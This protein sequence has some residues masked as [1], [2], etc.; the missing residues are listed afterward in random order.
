MKEQSTTKGFAILS[1]A[2]M[3]VKVLSILYIPFLLRI[4]GNEGYG[5]YMAAYQVYVFIYV[6][7]NS[8]IPVAISKMVSELIAVNNYRDAVKGFK[9]ARF[10]LL[11]LG[12]VLTV[13]MMIL[14]HPLAKFVHYEKASLAI[15]ALAPA[16]FFTSVAST[17]RG[18]FQGRGNMTPTAVSQVLEQITNTI[19]T[20]VFAG[21]LI[22]NG[23]AA[24]C[25]GGTIGT[26]LGA[27]V[28]AGY[29]IV[30]YEKNRR[31]K[32]PKGYKEMEV[33]RLTN[34]QILMR[35]IYYSLPL[36]LSVGLNYAGNFVD[37]ANVK[38]R[39]ISAGYSDAAGSAL[40]GILTRYQQ[41]LNVPIAIIS[42]LSAA[43]L[44]AIASAIAVKDKKRALDRIHYALRF[45]FLVAVPSAVGLAVLSRPIFTMLFTS[46]FADGAILMKYGSIVL[47]LM[48]IVQI[49]NAILQ[50]MGK[51][52]L[53]TFY[54]TLGIVGKIVTNYILVG[55]AQINIL[56]AV[57]GSM[58]CFVIPMLLN[59]KLIIRLVRGKINLFR[60]A[61][62]PVVSS[63]FMG[64]AA[65]ITYYLIDKGVGMFIRGYFTNALATVGA[66]VVGGIVYF[67][68]LVVTGGINEEDFSA[69]PGKMKRIIPSFIKRK[70]YR[71]QRA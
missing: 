14:A 55:I 57:F 53:S 27:L 25:A 50:G 12:T 8:G 66:I 5:V 51:L 4:I 37:L 15:F 68:G 26:S 48:S 59:H 30:I 64:L 71:E 65:Y 10:V 63:A 28:S 17:Y 13:L 1:A 34:K 43:I 46:K 21:L 45:C 22:K 41:L 19:L 3:M 35:I 39:L 11:I 69:L 47:V 67:Y 29:L 20:L 31:F 7:G 33:P 32:V 56:G 36:T 61:V 58:V 49:Q 44:P 24:A 16:I 42:A 6:L 38:I 18:Y 9:I 52:Y 2:G 54:L 60:H 62:K 70:I 23:I 40:F